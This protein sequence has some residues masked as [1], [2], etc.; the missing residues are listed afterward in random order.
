[1]R[2]TPL[3][4]GEGISTN[5]FLN[6]LTAEEVMYSKSSCTAS[7]LDEETENIKTSRTPR[8]YRPTNVKK[9]IKTQFIDKGKINKQKKR[10]NVSEDVSTGTGDVNCTYLYCSSVARGPRQKK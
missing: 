6:G 9:G 7:I 1:M 3:A 2:L 8:H 4:N 5:A 10:E